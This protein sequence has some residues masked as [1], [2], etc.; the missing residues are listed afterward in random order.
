MQVRAYKNR[1]HSKGRYFRHGS[2]NVVSS[3]LQW[4]KVVI[5]T[6]FLSFL[7][8]NLNLS[9]RWMRDDSCW[10]TKFALNREIIVLRPVRVW[11]NTESWLQAQI[12][13]IEKNQI[14]TLKELIIWQMY[15][16]CLQMSW[17]VIASCTFSDRE[18]RYPKVNMK[19]LQT[20]SL[21]SRTGV[22]VNR[23][24]MIL[25]SYLKPR[26]RCSKGC[27]IVVS[28]Y[29]VQP[30]PLG[31]TF[32]NAVSKL[33]AQSSKVSFHWNV[34]KESFN[35]ELWALANVTPSGTQ[36]YGLITLCAFHERVKSRFLV[37]PGC[38]FILTPYYWYE[39]F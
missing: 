8:F 36:K 26:Q 39:M 2:P 27:Q 20:K 19:S 10:E 30:T 9:E 25:R 14:Q 16:A 31:V 24:K 29:D 37:L 15:C 7:F 23:R 32:S 21:S 1:E 28:Q 4:A 18:S 12:F 11:E 3:Y 22:L 38:L 33:K 6:T 17:T 13:A 34:V 35:S 5:I